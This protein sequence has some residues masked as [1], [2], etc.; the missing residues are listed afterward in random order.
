[1]NPL[2][3]IIKSLKNK[4]RDDKFLRRQFAGYEIIV[5]VEKIDILYSKTVS[6]DISRF[7]SNEVRDSIPEFKEWC[8]QAKGII[9]GD[10]VVG[11]NYQPSFQFSRREVAQ[12]FKDKFLA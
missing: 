8:K 6:Q 1:M 10:F 5:P 11:I 9:L 12:E 3:N 2:K 7:G 4:R